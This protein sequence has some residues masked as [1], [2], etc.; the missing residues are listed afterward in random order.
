[1]SRRVFIAAAVL[2]TLYGGMLRFEALSGAYGWMGQPAW[3]ETLARVTNPVAR[4]LRPASIVWG[5]VSNPYVGSDPINYLAYAREMTNFYQAHV[6]E[7]LFLALT[8]CYLWLSGNRDISVS[9]ASVTGSTLAILATCLLGAAAFSRGVGLA[10]G[11]LLAIEFTAITRSIEGW[12]DDTFMCVVAF[13]AWSLIRLR[14]QPT[15]ARGVVAGVASAAACLTRITALSFVVPGLLWLLVEQRR[16]ARALKAT[17]VAA[18]VATLLF[19][20]YPI[21][22]AIVIG[23]PLFAIND[24]TRYYRAAEGLSPDAPMSVF[25]YLSGKVGTR[26]IASVDT[27]AQGLVTYPFLNRWDGFAP[28]SPLLVPL[29]RALSA[30][31]MIFAVWTAT[32][33]LLL[34][35]LTTSLLPYALTWTVGGGG[36]WRF[37]EHAYPFYLVFATSAIAVVYRWGIALVSD[38]SARRWVLSRGFAIRTGVVAVA[39]VAAWL[40]YRSLPFLM[41]REAL[42]SGE[43]V[44]I[45]T[46]P[47]NA[48]LFDGAW[49]AP[50]GEG[51]VIVRVAEAQIVGI[52]LPMPES[53]YWMTLRLDPAETSDPAL[54]PQVTVYLNRRPIAQLRLS[55]DPARVGSYRIRVP[56]DLTRTLS[57]LDLVATHTVPA[58]ESGIHFAGLPPQTSVAFRLW[59][60]RLEPG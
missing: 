12:R 24:H 28:W 15:I 32:G 50:T 26:P 1:M 2:I 20:P 39:A 23:D 18:L 13:S 7:P 3:A 31:G 25:S 36:E 16:D 21:S 56:K 58:A 6:R 45:S 53:D 47:R 14:Q 33:R 52:R 59:Y 22:C 17:G 29:L 11:F 57:R 48:W 35:L 19:A 9:Y 27:A 40:A 60:V 44:T 8:R 10:A 49:S 51:N 42:R 46:D 43:A 38:E 4:A 54:Q 37:T 34:I 41:Y 55:R 30:L 5:P